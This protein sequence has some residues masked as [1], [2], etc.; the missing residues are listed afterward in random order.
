MRAITA[1][2]L[3]MV[4]SIS[5]GCA[6][7]EQRPTIPPDPDLVAHWPM[8][9][10]KGEVIHDRSANR[11]HGDIP[12]ELEWH[13]EGGILFQGNAGDNIRIPNIPDYDFRETGQHSIMAWVKPLSIAGNHTVIRIGS[14]GRERALLAVA[15]G[16]WWSGGR[17][18]K[19]IGH[20]AFSAPAQINTWTHAAMI[21]DGSEFSLFLDGVKVQS[22]MRDSISWHGSGIGI[23][24]QPDDNGSKK[25]FEGAIRDV[26]IYRRALK[27]DEIRSVMD[28]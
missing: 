12:P 23:G 4:L 27:E 14:E 16:K 18:A 6:G 7:I 26:R 5:V 13:K 3:A 10:G 17:N 9:E 21:W 11:N 25:N 8:D 2:I 19:F 1:L 24:G 28:Q 22:V 15:T 20:R